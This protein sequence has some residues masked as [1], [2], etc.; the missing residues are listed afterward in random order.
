MSSSVRSRALGVLA[1]SRTGR[2]RLSRC[3]EPLNLI[4]RR[5]LSSFACR[6]RSIPHMENSS[7]ITE[8][9]K[10][11][12]PPEKPAVP[13]SSTP[14]AATRASARVTMICERVFSRLKGILRLFSTPRHAIGRLEK[15]GQF[16]A[17]LR[18]IPDNSRCETRN[19]YGGSGSARRKHPDGHV[20]LFSAVRRMGNGRSELVLSHSG[21]AGR[22]R[23][24]H[25]RQCRPER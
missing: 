11:I 4:Q 10:P 8:Q 17:K 12:S 15:D 5:R 7:L 2:Q 9:S 24:R 21:E 14:G 19:R 6:A 18:R 1:A 13:S 25:L 23:H 22:Y 20:S 3:L 16:Q